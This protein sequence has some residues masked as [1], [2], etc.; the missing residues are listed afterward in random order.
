M[1]I[2]DLDTGFYDKYL[3][4]LVKINNKEAIGVAF[5]FQK[6]K[7]IPTSKFDFQ[8]SRIY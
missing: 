2:I 6:Y 4:N 8:L 7:K 5:S 3:N 1:K